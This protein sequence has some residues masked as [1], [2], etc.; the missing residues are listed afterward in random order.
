MNVKEI[1]IFF[2]SGWF[3]WESIQ[4]MR[5]VW[6]KMGIVGYLSL[7]RGIHDFE[8]LNW[9]PFR[10]FNCYVKDS[11]KIFR[12]NVLNNFIPPW[13]NFFILL[14]F[15]SNLSNKNSVNHNNW[16]PLSPSYPLFQ[17]VYGLRT[18]FRITLPFYIIFKFIITHFSSQ[19]WKLFQ[20][21]Y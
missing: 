11:F 8:G 18:F 17:N 16:P 1:N 21:Y 3:F 13:F 20:S 12:K 19:I 4:D 14:Y 7:F 2:H 15:F 6:L 10:I 9:S 5:G